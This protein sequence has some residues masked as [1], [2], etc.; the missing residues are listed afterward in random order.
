[1]T[2]KEF[3]GRFKTEIV[4]GEIRAERLRQ[5]CSE[6]FTPEHDDQHID[7][8][9]ALAAGSYCESAARPSL[10]RRKSGFA[11]AIP[12]LWPLSWS[13]NWWKPKNPRADLVRAGALVVAEIERL[14]RAAA[15]SSSPKGGSAGGE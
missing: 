11:F 1:M 13:K 15:R 14:D 6:S 7:R 4:I 12:K 2:E 5:V 8:S 10:L 3:K 9:L